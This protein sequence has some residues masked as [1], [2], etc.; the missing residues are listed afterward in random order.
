[1]R[2]AA[3]RERYEKA[4]GAMKTLDLFAD[5]A[6]KQGEITARRVRRAWT[7]GDTEELRKIQTT[8]AGGLFDFRGYEAEDVPWLIDW[9]G[10]LEKADLSEHLP[11][12]TARQV[13]DRAHEALW[14]LT[15]A[16]GIG[17][18]F[19][20]AVDARDK[21]AS[22]GANM[23]GA[24]SSTSGGKSPDL[25]SLHAAALVL[26]RRGGDYKAVLEALKGEARKNGGDVEKARDAVAE[27]MRSGKL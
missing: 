22:H 21:V 2:D 24:T 1:M 11:E 18:T 26:T 27:R 12:A 17:E 4:V 20:K 23:A 19:T 13:R 6:K 8:P 15:A 5:L 3:S 14:K 10:R 25:A 9:F 7:S 16:R